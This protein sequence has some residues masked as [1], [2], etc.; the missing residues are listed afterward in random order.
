MI[1]S[2][3]DH[4]R[5]DF[6]FRESPLQLDLRS[7]RTDD[8]MTAF[9]QLRV[10]RPRHAGAS[11][12]AASWRAPVVA[13]E[14]GMRATWIE[15]GDATRGMRIDRPSDRKQQTTTDAASCRTSGYRSL[16]EGHSGAGS[17]F[18]GNAP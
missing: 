15:A 5:R 3:G 14:T 7:A 17:G 11:R 18:R 2:S 8:P 16:D 6:S 10:A 13:A 4:R 9:T 1:H 12:S